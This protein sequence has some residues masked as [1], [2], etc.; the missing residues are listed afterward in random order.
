MSRRHFSTDSSKHSFRQ[1]HLSH[2]SDKINRSIGGISQE[3]FDSAATY[4]EDQ[5][6]DE[7]TE[8]YFTNSCSWKCILYLLFEPVWEQFIIITM[9]VNLVVTTIYYS[10][11]FI[12]D[13]EID[14]DDAP[15]TLHSLAQNSKAMILFVAAFDLICD[16]LLIMD[17][18]L[19]LLVRAISDMRISYEH[20]R[21]PIWLIF[22]NIISGI[23]HIVVKGIFPNASSELIY[24][25][26]L[27]DLLKIFHIVY[28][29]YANLQMIRN[30]R[31]ILAVYNFFVTLM[32]FYVIINY[33]FFFQRCVV[34]TSDTTECSKA[35]NYINLISAATTISHKNFGVLPPESNLIV[36]QCIFSYITCFCVFVPLLMEIIEALIKTNRNKYIFQQR[37]QMALLA[38]TRSDTPIIIRKKILKV[39][40]LHWDKLNGY[41]DSE[42]IPFLKTFPLSVTSEL[43]IDMNFIALKHSKLFQNMDLPFLRCVAMAMEQ[44]FAV[45]GEFLY[46]KD[47]NK[48]KMIYIVSGV[49]QVLS[50]EDV[51]STI[52]SLSG[53]TCLGE[54]TLIINY[55][56]LSSIL[57][58]EYCVLQTL[59]M[60]KLVGIGKKFPKQVQRLKRMVMNRYDMAK[61]LNT[62]GN[63][64]CKTPDERKNENKR[65][66]MWLNNTLHRLMMKD[67]ETF[68]KH[69]YQNIFL[70]E[71]FDSSIH[72]SMTSTA[73][74]LDLLAIT[75][76]AELESDSI[77]QHTNCIPPILRPNSALL[78][79]WNILVCIV[80]IAVC[81]VTP[82]YSFIFPQTP[83]WFW[84]LLSVA[85]LFYI[86]DIYVITTTAI[87][88]TN[89]IIDHFKGIV[90]YQMGT[91]IFW[92]DLL[93]AYPIDIHAN[94]MLHHTSSMSHASF[95]LNRCFKFMKIVVIS[96]RYT[97]RFE[98]FRTLVDYIEFNS[99]LFYIAYLLTPMLHSVFCRLGTY[100][101]CFTKPLIDRFVMYYE[102][103]AQLLYLYGMPIR[104]AYIAEIIMD[105][106]MT[107]CLITITVLLFVLATTTSKKIMTSYLQ[108]KLIEI[109]SNLNE[110][111]N[112][113]EIG[114]TSRN[115]IWDYISTQ[116]YDN[117]CQK[118]FAVS[119]V[120]S[121][122]P[123]STYKL[124]KES[125][126]EKYV[127]IMPLFKELSDEMIVELCAIAEIDIL[128]PKEVVYYKGEP[129]ATIYFVV[130]GF[131]E[132]NCG[133][134]TR[135]TIGPGECLSVFEAYLKFPTLGTSITLTHCRLLSFPWNLVHTLI[136]PVDSVS[137]DYTDLKNQFIQIK[138]RNSF[139]INYNLDKDLYNASFKNFG[140]KL[141]MDSAEE[142]EYYV[143]FDR[144]Q[145]FWFIQYFLLR[146]TFLP[147]G[148]FVFYW[149][150]FRSIITV[151]SAIL[152]TIPPVITC[153][154][155]VWRWILLYLDLMALI[156]I[157]LKFHYCYY[158]D[159]GLLV[160][161]PLK[162]ASHYLKH[163]FVIDLITVLPIRML[164]NVNSSHENQL[165][166]LIHIVKC[167][168]FYR[169]HFLL[170]GTSL[171]P[172]KFSYIMRYLFTLIITSTVV[173]TLLVSTYCKFHSDI[174]DTSV[175]KGGVTCLAESIFSNHFLFS[176][177]QQPIDV[178]GIYMY[179]V[180]VVSMY[181]GKVSVKQFS[182][183][184]DYFWYITIEWL[185]FVCGYC[186][187]VY[188]IS[189]FSV[190]L[191]RSMNILKY[192]RSLYLLKKF[193]KR[194]KVSPN[195][196]KELLRHSELQWEKHRD[197]GL[198]TLTKNFHET[199]RADVIYDVYGEILEK[200][201]VFLEVDRQFYR[202]LLINCKH[203]AFGK[204]STICSVNDI[205]SLIYIVYEGY[206]KV[207]A[208]DG[209]ILTTLG[210]GSM[211][212]NLDDYP[213]VR[214]TVG[215][216][217]SG[218]VKV[219][220]LSTVDYF[221]ILKNY[222]RL[223]K[224]FKY[225]TS[226]HIDYL[227]GRITEDETFG[228][229]RWQECFVSLT[230][231]NT[232][233]HFYKIWKFVQLFFVCYVSNCLCIYLV[234]VNQHSRFL[235]TLL[236]IPDI[237]YAV[238]V[239]YVR[240]RS[241]FRDKDGNLIRNLRL[242]RDKQKENKK[243]LLIAKASLIP[244]EV[245]AWLF[246]K[247]KYFYTV[248][249]Y[250][251][252]NRQLR[253]Y[254][255]Y[256]YLNINKRKLLS[257]HDLFTCIELACTVI[258]TLLVLGCIYLRAS[259]YEEDVSPTGA[260]FDCDLIDDP[261]ADWHKK[262]S[263]F[264]ISLYVAAELLLTVNQVYHVSYDLDVL[265]W[266]SL[267]TLVTMIFAT[268]LF[269]EI[270]NIWRNSLYWR[271]IYEA[272]CSHL[273]DFM[274]RREVSKPLLNKVWNYV[275]FL[276][277]RQLG[278]TFPE[279]LIGAPAPLKL[280][281]IGSCYM[282][283]IK[284]NPLFKKCHEDFVKQLALTLRMDTYFPGDYIAFKGDIDGCMYFIHK[285]SILIMSE[286]T[287]RKED[288]V[289]K[290]IV[291]QSFGILQG[292]NPLMP[293]MYYYQ[294]T[295]KCDILSLNSEAWMYL[296]DYFPASKEVI[297]N[298]AESYLAL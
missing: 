2:Y 211:F 170:K 52:V 86:I 33:V 279:L 134:N 119:D 107:I 215:F 66:I 108:I 61:R 298:S 92:F 184:G 247:S 14:S 239:F 208:P 118:L 89:P 190:L 74:F 196:Q 12:E 182:N 233:K 282:H 249:L 85:T 162:T 97:K 221:K 30:Q 53:G 127:R 75:E 16:I 95:F 1:R 281:V 200:T 125:N 128:P 132:L 254:D 261:L 245:V 124:F 56:S 167:L 140:Y 57:C 268:Y 110:L 289:G 136:S 135:H 58:K 180:I 291:G 148:K 77:F 27:R 274:K 133:P 82:I 114:N 187:Y 228:K 65:R 153:S 51:D 39:F 271:S 121:D 222:P 163:S 287:C 214:Q 296:L 155:C 172:T 8:E 226:M 209:S 216:V 50:E 265:F 192:K 224:N 29:M 69:V 22:T 259:C 195:I 160:T 54:T 154:N 177:K 34:E 210:A 157:Y 242:I 227:P 241:T 253:L 32:C 111:A 137:V 246:P 285:G 67:E 48:Y 171:V 256:S 166:A 129:V 120:F 71:D 122:M 181:I 35:D 87:I 194:Q 263:N 219:L 68:F 72:Q 10:D 109:T 250:L 18:V 115:R 42:L 175:F 165:N 234:G 280:K 225:L 113:L 98:R 204:N 278:V 164:F 293:H 20:V 7:E 46:Q 59:S 21:R 84:V 202:K 262:L 131:V 288:I 93:A 25:L 31:M 231:I 38:L 147:N 96:R 199:L 81:F 232:E 266:T 286:D 105:L 91:L 238:D 235:Q 141:K 273:Y 76:R 145:I 83:T 251:R 260:N 112:G 272:R 13:D 203:E 4:E 257:N 80:A 213:R 240:Y 6:E 62:L 243:G 174:P 5:K 237:L 144:L 212:G 64:L 103:V 183:I 70:R 176:I 73:T 186:C 294:A 19:M 142:Y 88:D 218:T 236:Y 158:N 244:L 223:S 126:F 17:N 116:W 290:L 101:S 292:I 205:M 104:G 275:R 44:T 189:K 100:E 23:P 159:N 45:P 143:P 230:T 117:S 201:S 169:V 284:K 41:T 188:L 269:A 123:L 277:K 283:H 94:S 206:V 178:K 26:Q 161:H 130:D 55:N 40:Q 258:L 267:T 139:D 152:F 106:Y 24:Y 156:D 220:V 78:N 47:K 295:T 28:Y 49:V 197:N 252:L 99:I 270:Y 207:V 185:L 37:K 168:Q 79:I 146:V 151:A 102:I 297:Y 63:F 191:T 179:S 198:Y 264:G 43:V 9:I 11:Q 138:E 149:E 60:D 15:G 3:T 276:W 248:P 229:I 255:L 173:S 36:M 217:A 90:A 193:M 150:I